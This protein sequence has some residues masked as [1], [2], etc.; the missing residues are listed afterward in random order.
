MYL[1]LGLGCSQRFLCFTVGCSKT[2]N[3]IESQDSALSCVFL[4]MTAGSIL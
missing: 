2:W 3:L 4:I 1:N